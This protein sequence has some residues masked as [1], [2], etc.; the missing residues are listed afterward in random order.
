MQ[1]YIAIMKNLY[2]YLYT[3]ITIWL[4]LATYLSCPNYLHGYCI[5]QII[6]K[7]S[8][9]NIIIIH[10]IICPSPPKKGSRQQVTR[11]YFAF[12]LDIYIQLHACMHASCMLNSYICRDTN[13]L[14]EEYLVKQLKYYY[15]SVHFVLNRWNVVLHLQDQ[16][17]IAHYIQYN[18][19]QSC[20]YIYTCMYVYMY[21]A[22]YIYTNIYQAK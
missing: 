13:K 1:L 7:H 21:M 8:H 20:C 22:I 6:Y 4:Q 17:P 12:F 15:T 2:N 9:A 5:Y 10:L 11:N 3:S 19:I 18:S 14:L 16:K